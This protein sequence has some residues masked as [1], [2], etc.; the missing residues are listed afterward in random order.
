MQAWI[1]ITILAA[2]SQNLRFMLQK[3][4]KDTRL[5]ATGATFARFVYSAPLVA[6]LMAAYFVLSGHEVPRPEARFFLFA[7]VGGIAQILA[8]ICVVALFAE[9]N[10]AVG[11]TFKKTEVVLTALTGL[12]VLGE[13]VKLAGALAIVIGFLGLILL[14]DPPEGGQGWRRFFNKAAALG[15][16]AGLLFSFSAIGYRGASLSLDVDDVISRAGFTL[17]VVTAFQSL[18][19][20][21]WMALREKGEI[22]RVFAA[23]R[24]GVLV[25]LSSMIG[26]FCWFTA[27]T[28]QNAALVKALG[29][30]ELLFSYA[31]T[32]FVFREKV[33][34]REYGGTALI[35]VSVLMLVLFLK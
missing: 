13:G 12:L 31:A 5:S 21:T 3:R 19:M 17:A 24:V 23:W 11:I 35:L 34:G 28:L 22:R 20:A 8:T 16:G 29:Q 26:S 6:L 27:F 7:S 30:I 33:S 18:V 10:F 25:G 1:P 32:I 9:R 15:L 14:S 2:F 4:L